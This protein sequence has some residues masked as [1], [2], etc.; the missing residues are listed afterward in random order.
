MIRRCRRRAVLPP[1]AP[2]LARNER[3]EPEETPVGELLRVGNHAIFE[4]VPNRALA[5][6]NHLEA[7]LS[8]S[9]T[10]VIIRKD[11]GWA[12]SSPRAPRELAGHDED[13]L[14]YR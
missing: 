3:E 10:A 14:A 2:A 9:R 5:P 8:L 6:L 1:P 11:G 7:S 12:C 13:V 4:E